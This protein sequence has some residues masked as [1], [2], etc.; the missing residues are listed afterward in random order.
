MNKGGR[1][2]DGTDG[3]W[4]FAP[5]GSDESVSLAGQFLFKT[6]GLDQV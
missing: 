5:K 2:G 6:S 1:E 4:G 3:G